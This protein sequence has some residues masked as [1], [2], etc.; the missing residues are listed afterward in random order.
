MTRSY[1]LEKIYELTKQVPKGKVT[2][3]AAIADAL[4][5]PRAARVVGFVMS[6]CPYPASQVPCH[7][8]IRSDGRIGGYGAEGSKKKAQLLSKEGIEI[9]NGKVDLSRFLFLEFRRFP[10]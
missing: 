6:V 2:T 4:N 1:F 3:Y 10:Q 9:K 8:V 7:R 5:R